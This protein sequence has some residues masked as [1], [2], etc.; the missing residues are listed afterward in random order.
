MWKQ[1][2]EAKIRNQAAL[3]N[4]L[5]KNGEIMNFWGKVERAKPSMPQQLDFFSYICSLK[6]DMIEKIASNPLLRSEKVDF[7]TRQ[8]RVRC[9]KSMS[10]MPE[11]VV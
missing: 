10:I 7:L 8:M 9:T 6:Y 1:I 4:K 11:V 2:V 5:G 3:L